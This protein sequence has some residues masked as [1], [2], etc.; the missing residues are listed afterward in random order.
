MVEL[1]TNSREDRHRSGAVS[2]RVTKKKKTKCVEGGRKLSLAGRK[3][4]EG[5]RIFTL[6]HQWLQPTDKEGSAVHLLSQE[7]KAEV[8]RKEK[9]KRKEKRLELKQKSFATHVVFHTK[10]QCTNVQADIV[11]VYY[12][13]YINICVTILSI[14]TCN[15]SF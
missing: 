13:I 7:V 6:G 1:A 10:M 4:A 14:R 15:A 5:P 8:G 3:D 2:S 12:Y 11:R 9:K